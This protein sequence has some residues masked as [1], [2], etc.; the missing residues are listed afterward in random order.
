MLCVER[1]ASGDNGT[2]MVKAK[3]HSEAAKAFCR[4]VRALLETELSVP[5]CT[6]A[7]ADSAESL[8]VAVPVTA[9]VLS[10]HFGHCEQFFLFDVDVDG[11]TFKDK[12]KLAPPPHE[13]G[14]F[15]KWL[16]EH[17]ATTII[18]GGMGSRAQSLFAQ[19][20]IRVVLGA[21]GEPDVLVR[22]FLDGTL[23]TGA[24]VCDH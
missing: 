7:R 4:V 3:P 13:P 15:P 19:D 23:S 14:T 18:A 1:K 9:G 6:Q 5:V 16:S 20:G 24:N 8:R 12:K 17:G 21:A 10:P 2:P 11:K 22:Q